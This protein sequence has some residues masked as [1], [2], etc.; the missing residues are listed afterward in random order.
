MI[1]FAINLHNKNVKR[2][3]L[4]HFQ[5]KYYIYRINGHN[6]DILKV[7]ASKLYLLSFT[8]ITTY[9][10]LPTT[11]TKDLA[12][13]QETVQ[14]SNRHRQ[15]RTSNK[16]CGTLHVPTATKAQLKQRLQSFSVQIVVQTLSPHNQDP[17]FA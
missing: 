6:T 13:L 17:Y 4:L 12:I 9:D 16:N 1:Y 2:Q 8:A 5:L 15:L 14:G 10:C 3:C 7:K 11:T